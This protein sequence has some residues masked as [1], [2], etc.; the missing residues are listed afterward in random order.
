MK[1][2]DFFV[3]RV[4][5]SDYFIANSIAMAIL[6][7]FIYPNENCHCHLEFMGTSNFPTFE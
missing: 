1:I 7:I 6:N 4:S 5:K 3:G 2:R